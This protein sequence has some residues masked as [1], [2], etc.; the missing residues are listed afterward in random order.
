MLVRLLL[1]APVPATMLAFV[2]I[3]AITNQKGG[4]AKTT[5]AVNL[6]AGLAELGRR[7]LLVDWDSSGAATRWLCGPA[8]APGAEAIAESIHTPNPGQ[9]L[10]TFALRV[11]DGTAAFDFLP[12]SKALVSLE[13]AWAIDPR[14]TVGL[15]REIRHLADTYDV[16]IIDTAPT[17]SPLVISAI[18]AATQLLIPCEPTLLAGSALND[19]VADLSALAKQKVIASVPAKLVACR[20]DPRTRHARDVLELLQTQGDMA[21]TVIRASVRLQE[22][23]AVGKWIG[24]YAPDSVSAADYRLLAA[25]VN[26]WLL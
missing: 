10:N 24:A 25:E 23:P 12:S 5:T 19:Y 17:L 26:G 3:L 6:S 21:Q 22:S 14:G 2:H 18:R 1:I 4:V 16:A 7:I 20:V 13:R 8:K 15:G 9:R 11:G